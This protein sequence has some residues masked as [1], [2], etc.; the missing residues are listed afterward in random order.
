MAASS[1]EIY[2]PKRLYTLAGEPIFIQCS[3]Q[4]NEL[5]NQLNGKYRKQLNADKFFALAIQCKVLR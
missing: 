5:I 4:L 3:H 2:I 1:A